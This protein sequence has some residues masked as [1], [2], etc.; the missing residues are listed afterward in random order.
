MMQFSIAMLVAFSFLLWTVFQANIHSLIFVNIIAVCLYLYS[1]VLIAQIRFDQ[2][3]LLITITNLFVIAFHTTVYGTQSGFH[4]LIWPTACLFAINTSINLAVARNIFGLAIL[5]FVSLQYFIPHSTEYEFYAYSKLVFIGVGGTLLLL[6]IVTMSLSVSKRR[7][8]L[9]RLANRDNLTDLYN[10]R[11]FT[12]F[13]NYQLAVSA[14]EKRSFT[15]AMADIDHFKSINDNHGHDVGDKVL[16]MVSECFQTYL[17]QN[18]TSCRWGGEEFLI[19]LPESRVEYAESVIQA[20]ASVVSDNAIDG[21]S[22]TMSFGLVE[23]DGNESLDHL[24]QRVDALLYQAKAQGRNNIQ[25]K[26]LT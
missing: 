12:S 6:S 18:D 19:Y 20:I 9:Q 25:T 13:L 16:K 21:L 11:Y 24:L 23:S 8:K 14:R 10:R 26:L 22:I 1:L 7:N 15:L 17:G 4:M 5:I 3:V 2:A